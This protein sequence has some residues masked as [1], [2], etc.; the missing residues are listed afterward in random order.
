MATTSPTPD[1]L[2]N[3]STSFVCGITPSSAATT[4]TTISVTEAPLALIPVNAACP[5]VSRKVI[6]FTPPSERDSELTSEASGTENAPICCVI[7]PA[8]PDATEVWRRESR[9]VVLP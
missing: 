5:G 8:S 6:L 1:F 4:S 7:P 9:R 3:S 2:T